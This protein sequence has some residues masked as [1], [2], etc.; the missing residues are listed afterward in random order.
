MVSPGFGY[1]LAFAELP[2]AKMP[3]FFNVSDA[4]AKDLREHA[5]SADE[6][7][8]ARKPA[9]E[10]IITAQQTN[11]YWAYELLGA[12]TDP[13]RLD[14]IRNTVYDL[15]AVTAVEVQQLAQIYLTTAKTWRAEIKPVA[16]G[17]H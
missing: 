13:R 4:I 1:L 10:S 11:N 3:L 6:L 8:R 2:P 14:I 12:Q 15:K 7:E 16:A 9:V 17:S 5:I